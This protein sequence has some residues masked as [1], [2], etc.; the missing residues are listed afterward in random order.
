MWQRAQSF[1]AAV[2]GAT[3]TMRGRDVVS[4]RSQL[5][6]ASQSIAANI[7]EGANAAGARD[8]ARYLQISIGSAS[9]TESHLDLARRTSVVDDAVAMPLIDEVVEI[10]RMLIVLRRRVLAG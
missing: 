7:A 10:R 1:A 5:R 9:E 4:L 3:T 6:R 2:Y 8:F